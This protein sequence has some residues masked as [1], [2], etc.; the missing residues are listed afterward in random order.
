ME[1]DSD[2]NRRVQQYRLLDLPGNMA[3]RILCITL[4]EHYPQ[5]CMMETPRYTISEL[6]FSKFPDSGDFQCWTGNFKTEVCVSA[7]F[8]QITMSWINEVEMAKSIDDV[9]KS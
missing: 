8:P 7:P 1:K 6:H 9:L 4:E 5:N 2:E 3:P